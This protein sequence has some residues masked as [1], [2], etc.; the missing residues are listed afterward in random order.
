M[1]DKTMFADLLRY[2]SKDFWKRTK[3]FTF[4]TL[5]ETH[6]Y[7]VVAVFKTSGTA[8]VGF[9][10]HVFVNAS[11]EEQFNEF[12]AEIHKMQMYDTGVTAK[13]GDKLLC[14]CTCEYTMDNG[15]FVVVAKRVS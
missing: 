6:T 12:M 15:R 10:F 7:Q 8:G 9:P 1:A 14:L 11:S 4:D 2:T 3:T 13:Y 5:Y